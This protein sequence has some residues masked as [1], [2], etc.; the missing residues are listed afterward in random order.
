MTVFEEGEGREKQRKE[1]TTLAEKRR[2]FNVEKRAYM[3]CLRTCVR[4][5]G[6]TDPY[7]TAVVR[8]RAQCAPVELQPCQLAA[9]HAEHGTFVPHVP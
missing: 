4:V 8:V 2:K 6:S 1:P 3:L 7:Y 5:D 9:G